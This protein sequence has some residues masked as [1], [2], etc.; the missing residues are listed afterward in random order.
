MKDL[1]NWMRAADRKPLIVRGARQVGK[2]TLVRLFAAQQHRPLIEV[3]L[4][5]R[6][7]IGSIFETM[8]PQSIFGQ[9]EALPSMPRVTAESMLFLDEIQAAPAAIA[10]L[11]YFYEERAELP[12]IAA[13]SLMEFALA[14][15]RLA[16]PVGRVRYLHMGPMV[17]TEFL[18]ALGESK[19]KEA[20]VAYEPGAQLGPVVHKRLLELLRRYYFVGGMPAAVDVLAR[21][22]KLADVSTVHTELIET[23]RDDFQKYARSRNLARMQHVLEFAARNVGTK[24]KYANVL[25]DAHSSTIRQ[26]IELLA[27]ARVVSKVLHTRASGLPLLADVDESVYKLL[28]L[29]VGLMNAICELTWRTLSR[30]PDAD[31]INGG[32]V[33]EQFVGQHLLEMLADSPNRELTYWLRAG[34]S[35]NAEVDFVIAIEG[36]IVPVEVKAGARGSLRSLHQFIAEK[37][38]PLA[39]RFDTN[40]PS[41]QTVATTVQTAAGARHVE[42]ELLSLP[43]Y[44]VERT[45]DLVSAAS[46]GR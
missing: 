46:A 5:R 2:S 34:R 14:E 4:E 29:D 13:G 36:A 25:R 32:A 28:F 42:Y 22:G 31:L 38:A 9:I 30:Q 27:M 12:V 41:R 44:L 21:T 37:H 3:N 24:V 19:L 35:S 43:L 15:R 7:E 18:E 45:A 8:D 40:P 39:V 33:A 6:P 11:R 10:A 26:D 1:E 23:Y 16:M 17:F 20:I